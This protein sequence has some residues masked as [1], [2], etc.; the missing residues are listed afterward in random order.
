ML[1][2]VQPLEYE[3]GLLAQVVKLL[4]Y[5]EREVAGSTRG[6]VKTYDYHKVN[7]QTNKTKRSK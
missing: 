5:A 2:P 6:Q 3:T 1:D 7:K 4:W